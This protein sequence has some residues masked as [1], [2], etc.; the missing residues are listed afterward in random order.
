ML[1]WTIFFAIVAIVVG[2]LGFFALAGVVAVG[3]KILFAV[4]AILLLLSL[5][6]R[7]VRSAP[8]RGD[9]PA[10]NRASPPVP[11][12]KTPSATRPGPNSRLDTALEES[13]L[14]IELAQRL[15]PEPQQGQR[16][17]RGRTPLF[18]T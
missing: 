8:A 13:A 16:Q 11:A 12:T 17:P 3:A 6:D 7:P 2:G 4:F 15:G 18:R 10:R 1:R 9:R 14:P 5:R